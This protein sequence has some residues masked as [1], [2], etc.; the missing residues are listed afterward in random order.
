MR[1]EDCGLRGTGA[2]EGRPYEGQREGNRGGMGP[3]SARATGGGAGRERGALWMRGE[4]CG[5]KGTGAHE[6]RPYEGQREGNRGGMGP[7]LR[8]DNGSGKE[9]GFETRP[10][11]QMGA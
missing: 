9:G 6:G 5:L 2:R 11:R 7:R 3:R 8:E 10:Y 1:G 4:D